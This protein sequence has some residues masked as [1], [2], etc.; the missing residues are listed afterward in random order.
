MGIDFDIEQ[1]FIVC[2]KEFNE[3][4]YLWHYYMDEHIAKYGMPPLYVGCV[5]YTYDREYDIDKT[6]GR[7]KNYPAEN[8]EAY[9]SQEARWL[10]KW[11]FPGRYTVSLYPEYQILNILGEE[12]GMKDIASYGISEDNNQVTFAIRLRNT[13][14]R[15]IGIPKDEDR[16]KLELK[17]ILDICISKGEGSSSYDGLDKMHPIID[18]NNKTKYLLFFGISLG[19]PSKEF[20][21]SANQ[22][23]TIQHNLQL[24]RYGQGNLSLCT[25]VEGHEIEWN[26]TTSCESCNDFVFDTINGRSVNIEGYENIRKVY[27]KLLYY[28]IQQLGEP[29]DQEDIPS[30]SRK[31]SILKLIREG[32]AE[33]RSSFE[34]NNIKASIEII[35]DEDEKKCGT[36]FIEAHDKRLQKINSTT[37]KPIQT[38]TEY[39][40]TAMM[41]AKT[42]LESYGEKVEQTR[43]KS[44]EKEDDYGCLLVIA[45]VVCVIGCLPLAY[46]F[47]AML[48]GDSS[49]N[50]GTWFFGI[51]LVLL[52]VFIPTSY[53]SAKLEDK[54]GSFSGGG[55][56][57]R[58]RGGSIGGWKIKQYDPAGWRKKNGTN[59]FKSSRRRSRW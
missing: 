35:A 26:F 34:T 31:T 9:L 56:S 43:S 17:S 18:I 27:D 5:N 33:I 47:A 16:A 37:Y 1:H 24:K 39:I 23:D 4:R 32:D 28:L 19:I 58:G 42:A 29:T 21:Y 59:L 46:L 45:I 20:L 30:N 44:K 52:L 41:A 11:K 54:Y 51:Y 55:H 7:A 15:T 10:Q 6:L 49:E 22:L 13:Q 57:Y 38:K 8:A 2:A 12:L 50:F 40:N 14:F 25:D 53:F 36:I 48:E 3:A